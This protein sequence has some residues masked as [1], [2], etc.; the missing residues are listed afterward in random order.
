MKEDMD[1]AAEKHNW[2]NSDILTENPEVAASNFGPGRILP[3]MYKGEP[4]E[5]AFETRRFQQQQVEEKKVSVRT[6]LT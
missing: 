4:P 2:M 5:R 3:H 6:G 1:K